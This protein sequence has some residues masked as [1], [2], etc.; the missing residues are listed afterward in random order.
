[1]LC[2]TSEIDNIKWKEG[3]CNN[4][5]IDAWRNGFFAHNPEKGTAQGY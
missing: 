3:I 1:M 2:R 5:A 4:S